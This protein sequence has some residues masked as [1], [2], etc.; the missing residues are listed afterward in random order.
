M[1]NQNNI[2]LGKLE[3]AGS[4]ASKGERC[5]AAANR[6]LILAT[7]EKLFAQHGVEN[8]NMAQI[9]QE[10]QV[11]KG[12]IYRRFANKADLCL[13]LMDSQM[14]D[15]QNVMLERMRKM[16][17]ENVTPLEQLDQFLDALV[18]FIEDHAPLLCEVQREGL[19]G[20][21]DLQVPHFWLHMTT[22]GLLRQAIEVGELAP[23]LDVEYIADAL[24]A[25]LRANVFRFQR[26]VRG[27]SLER[28]SA[29]LRTLVA[30]LRFSEVE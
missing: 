15:F 1:S 21:Y 5:D 29:G 18:Y 27:F 9:A 16:T 4:A 25:S 22:S 3:V 13:A 7:A 10:A 14:A 23:Q 28:I 2:I 24:L 11:G 8:V 30:G 20:T 17:A 26:Q 6:K 12:T 19:L